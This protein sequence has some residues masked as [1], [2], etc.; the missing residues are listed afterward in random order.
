MIGLNSSS[1]ESNAVT[2]S[3]PIF[4][5]MR[6]PGEPVGDVDGMVQIDRVRFGLAESDDLLGR[7]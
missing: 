4:V 5:L 6:M 7:F 2:V 1:G 3:F